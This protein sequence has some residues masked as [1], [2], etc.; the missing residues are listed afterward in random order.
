MNTFLDIA[1]VVLTGIGFLCSFTAMPGDRSKPIRTGRYLMGALLI[2]LGC[3]S[4][5]V[6]QLTTPAPG[7]IIIGIA[8]VLGALMTITAVLVIRREAK[9]PLT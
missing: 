7:W 8:G 4:L 3:I 6:S 1:A 2:V 9:G 5:I